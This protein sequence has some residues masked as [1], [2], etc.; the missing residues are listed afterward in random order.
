MTKNEVRESSILLSNL[1]EEL[2]GVM[3]NQK[4]YEQQL[5]AL[6]KMGRL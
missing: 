5:L 2:L 3:P 1:V 6:K 4:E